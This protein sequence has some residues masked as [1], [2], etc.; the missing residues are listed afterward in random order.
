MDVPLS[1]HKGREGRDAVPDEM[2]SL[3]QDVQ[4]GVGG[5][6]L[7]ADHLHLQPETNTHRS[8]VGQELR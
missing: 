4:V 2:V 7:K 8:A 5:V 1:L 6:R 3:A